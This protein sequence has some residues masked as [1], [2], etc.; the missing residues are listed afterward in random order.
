MKLKSR[1]ALKPNHQSKV[2][3]QREKPSSRIPAQ[4]QKVLNGGY[5]SERFSELLGHLRCGPGMRNDDFNLGH[6]ECEV[7]IGQPSGD[8]QQTVD[9]WCGTGSELLACR[10]TLVPGDR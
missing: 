7:S 1:Q 10:L 5:K 9:L 2:A 4:N 8:V 6:A 3:K